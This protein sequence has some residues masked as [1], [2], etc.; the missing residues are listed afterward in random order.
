[1]WCQPP[2]GLKNRVVCNRL[3]TNNRSRGLQDASEL[4]IGTIEIE[5]ME[6]SVHVY[7]VKCVIRER[8]LL[9][10]HDLEMSLQASSIGFAFRVL[11]RSF[12]NID[13]NYVGTGF[14]H[15]KRVVPITAG[16]IKRS[17]ATA[18]LAQIALCEIPALASD[19][20]PLLVRREFGVELRIPL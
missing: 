7:E 3:D 6:D 2:I 16:V 18:M 14:G 17:G 8:H 5:V 1:M 20:V 11:Y 10:I 15:K 9:A 4:R 12:R 13:S 19:A